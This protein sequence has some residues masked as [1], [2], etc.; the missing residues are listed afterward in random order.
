MPWKESRIV[1][2]RLQFLSSYQ[3]KEM[4]LSDLCRE[5]GVSRPTGYRWINRYKEVGPEGLLDRSRKPHGC[6]HATSEATENAI[7]ALR[8]KHPSWGARKLKARLEKV[9]PRVNWLVASTFGNILHRAGLTNPKQKKLRTTP[10][11]EPFSE[12]T[13]PNQLWCMDFKGYFSTGDG[14]RCDPFTITDAHSRYLI[15]CQTVSRMDLSQVV[16]VCEAAMREYGM[17][18][19]IRTDN[20]APFAG[21]G[22]LGLS[23]LSLS[24]T[25]MGIVH[26]RIQPGRPQQNGRHE[27]MHRTLKEDTTKPPALTLRLQQKK[28][29]R[30]R[31]IF[32][33]E[34]P[35]EGL[36]NETPASLYQRSS[37]MFPRVL[38]PF[39]YPRGF[40]TRR[41]NPSGDISWHKD[42]VFISQVFSFE[43]LG[44]EEMDEEI[45]RVYFRE[46]EL[47]ELDVTELRFRP[48]RA[49]P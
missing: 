27:R 6:S 38:T 7:L 43:D 41:V 49:L 18:A 13:A 39:T 34:R 33:H 30:F 29:D 46:I 31:Q 22:L 1:D 11:S 48:V 26:E 28:F 19:R 12:V 16:S 17:P 44:F 20:G 24:W 10:C 40:Q 5:F 8:S 15:R 4:S 35:H 2:Q 32:N 37:I 47:G 14:T 21:T 3:K 36:N 9:R 23:K 42:R 25:K 45:F